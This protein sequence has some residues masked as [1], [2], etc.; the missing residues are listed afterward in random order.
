M[1]STKDSSFSNPALAFLGSPPYQAPGARPP[2]SRAGS[3]FAN[4]YTVSHYLIV[5]TIFTIM[6]IRNFS[7]FLLLTLLFFMYACNPETADLSIKRNIGGLQPFPSSGAI[8][9]ILDSII[10]IDPTVNSQSLLSESEVINSLLDEGYIHSGDKTTISPISSSLLI[11]AFFKSLVI[12]TIGNAD[13]SF[14]ASKYNSI[15][16]PSVLMYLVDV[17]S[18][19]SVFAAAVRGRDIHI[20]STTNYCYDMQDVSM[21]TDAINALYS[22]GLNL[23]RNTIDSIAKDYF[24]N[25]GRDIQTFF[26]KLT[27]FKRCMWILSSGETPVSDLQLLS[28]SKHLFYGFSNLYF[29]HSDYHDHSELAY[30][31]AISIAQF[32]CVENYTGSISGFT[33]TFRSALYNAGLYQSEIR[34]WIEDLYREI[35]HTSNPRETAFS[36][37]E[38]LGYSFSPAN[39]AQDVVNSLDDNHLVI[40]ANNWTVIEG[41]RGSVLNSFVH[42]YFCEYKNAC[43]HANFENLNALYYDCS[44][45]YIYQ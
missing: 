2:A 41:Y 3:R 7:G 13:L 4:F 38:D 18:E 29:T 14:R 22:S 11:P 40:N 42:A 16:V 37:L 6:K 17:N 1:T 15:H 21:F 23:D 10:I 44:V 5:Y 34:H 12:D 20:L 27:E 45:L 30:N 36:I 43:K 32:L 31:A 8:G 25:N 39:D 28:T 19:Y 26:D 35:L 9:S 33:G 24:A